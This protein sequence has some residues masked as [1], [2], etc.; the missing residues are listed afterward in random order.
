[1]P[2]LGI[3]SI[4]LHLHQDQRAYSMPSELLP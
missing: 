3:S 1:M 4:L 2:L